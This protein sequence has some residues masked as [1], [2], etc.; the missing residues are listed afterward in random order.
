LHYPIT[1]F[2]GVPVAHYAA[3]GYRTGWLLTCHKNSDSPFSVAIEELALTDNK[4]CVSTR[5]PSG[6]GV[7]FLL[8]GF[9]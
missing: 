8:G 2:N 7:N 4:A 3:M 6:R 9:L 1:H 5:G